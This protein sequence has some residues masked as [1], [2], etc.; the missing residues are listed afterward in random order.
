MSDHQDDPTAPEETPAESEATRDELIDTLLHPDRARHDELGR[1]TGTTPA[2]SPAAGP[3]E[4]PAAPID[5]DDVD[6]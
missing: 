4:Q 2:E 5:T 1:T 6:E 3:R